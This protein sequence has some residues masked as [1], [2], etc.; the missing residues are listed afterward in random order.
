MRCVAGPG[1]FPAV[2]VLVALLGVFA[3]AAEDDE[4][5]R[6]VEALC[7]GRVVVAEG[8]PAG[9]EVWLFPAEAVV[10]ALDLPL[11]SRGR[12]HVSRAPLDDWPD[13]AAPL[14]WPWRALVGDDGRFEFAFPSVPGRIANQGAVPDE[15]PTVVVRREGCVTREVAERVREVDPGLHVLGLGAVALP[16]EGR[17][18][19]QLVDAAGAGVEGVVVRRVPGALSPWTEAVLAASHPRAYLETCRAVTDAAGRFEL[20]AF[21]SSHD[22]RTRPSLL[23]DHPLFERREVPLP[24][25][26]V[27]RV[28]DLGRVTLSPGASASGTVTD[29]RGRPVAGAALHAGPEPARRFGAC[30]E[31]CV[32]PE[33]DTILLDVRERRG[34]SARAE[35]DAA[36]RYLLAG[37]PPEHPWMYVV[38]DGFEPA[39]VRVDEAGD[40]VLRD[41]A[42][43]DVTV[44]DDATGEPIPGASVVAE[45]LPIEVFP[46]LGV[47]VEVERLGSGRHLVHRAGRVHTRLH[48]SAD[49]FGSRA[50]GVP[51]VETGASRDVEVRLHRQAAVSGRVFD[52]DGAPL[53]SF[54]AW[55]LPTD[56]DP[57][58]V[59]PPTFDGRGD[60]WS[61]EGLD[62]GAWTLRAEAG[63]KVPWSRELVLEPGERRVL[64]IV[65]EDYVPLAVRVLDEDGEPVSGARVVAREVGGSGFPRITTTSRLL[66]GPGDYVVDSPGAAAVDVTVE[67]GESPTVTLELGTAPVLELRVLRGG[68]PVSGDHPRLTSLDARRPF[69]QLAPGTDED[70]RTSAQLPSAGRWEIRPQSMPDEVAAVVDLARGE[71][72]ELTVDLPAGATGAAVVELELRDE[73][74]EPVERARV[75]VLDGERVV[76]R[77]S[78]D[79]SGVARLPGLAAGTHRVRVSGP[80]LSREVELDATIE[81]ADP[82]RV[83]VDRG[84]RLE[85]T[86]DARGTDP[87]DIRSLRLIHEATDREMYRT[88]VDDGR[89]LFTGLEPGR[90]RLEL[91]LIRHRVTGMAFMPPTWH[92][93]RHVDLDLADHEHRKVSLRD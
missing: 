61:S 66:V 47:P 68:L 4:P 83:R 21:T 92:V 16:P 78:S 64:D 72:R 23:M 50:E 31:Y 65:L 3:R 14:D 86:Y 59:A 10:R 40:V 7:T 39:C 84:A 73:D 9:A 81:P 44:V 26:P 60:A 51:G 77:A 45:R 53:T 41:E 88:T 42:T 22:E 48:I 27:G 76:M 2:L 20:R 57:G 89:S 37:V 34:V 24:D 74:D 58:R 79:G 93:L 28:V 35:T 56:R 11:P 71:T 52:A 55:V 90:Y 43:L 85:V 91:G 36:G 29:E 69:S 1:A 19:G 15:T 12:V 30:P 82:T 67:R 80:V 70:G 33:D 5:P 6:L 38:A 75:E 54:Q 18:V 13:V 49:G 32:Y 25:V 8:S 87:R 46:S 62:P 63:G 17:L